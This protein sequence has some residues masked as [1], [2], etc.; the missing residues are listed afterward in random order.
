[1]NEGTIDILPTDMRHAIGNLKARLTQLMIC[2]SRAFPS[3][4]IDYQSPLNDGLRLS[5]RIWMTARSIPSRGMPGGRVRH[6]AA[7]N[8]RLDLVAFFAPQIRDSEGGGRRAAVRQRYRGDLHQLGG[9]SQA[10]L[11]AGH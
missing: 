4:L 9:C 3:A 11:T 2:C 10:E 8:T 1:V 5:F 7:P 6:L